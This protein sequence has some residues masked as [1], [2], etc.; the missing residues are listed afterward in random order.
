[1][2]TTNLGSIKTLL[3]TNLHYRWFCKEGTIIWPLISA[4]LSSFRFLILSFFSNLVCVS[5]VQ[6]TLETLIDKVRNFVKFTVKC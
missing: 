1:M 3:I 2:N 6:V 5:P 4:D